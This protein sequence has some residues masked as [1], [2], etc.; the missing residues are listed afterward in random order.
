MVPA[1]Q[2]AWFY[3]GGGMELME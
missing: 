1:E 2:Y 3:H